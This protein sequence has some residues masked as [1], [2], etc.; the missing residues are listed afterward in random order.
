MD[1]EPTMQGKMNIRLA[2]AVM[3]LVTMVTA[4][5]LRKR[6]SSPF[7]LRKIDRLVVDSLEDYQ[8]DDEPLQDESSC[9]DCGGTECCSPSTCYNSFCYPPVVLVTSAPDPS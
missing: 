2:L 8:I 3:M 9:P 1:V 5:D 4:L 7:D 6:G